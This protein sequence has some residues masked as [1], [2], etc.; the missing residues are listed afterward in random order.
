[1]GSAIAQALR[2]AGVDV[3]L[4]DFGIPPRFLDHASR[5]EVL[6]EIGLTA[7]D[8]ARQVT[9]LVAKL[10]GPPAARLR[11]DGEST[12]QADAEAVE[13]GRD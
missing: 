6:A 4:R 11:S 9:G 3:P 13:A 12:E 2:D 8:I 7:P 5:A 1:V 10:D